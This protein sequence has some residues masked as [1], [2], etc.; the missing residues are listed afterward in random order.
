M[1]GSL[2]DGAERPLPLTQRGRRARGAIID[3]AAT[4]MYQRG[5]SATSLDDVLAAAGSGKS[6]LYHYFADKA[7]LVAAVI[8]R[9]LEIVLAAQPALDHVDSWAGID[10]WAAE[11]L[12]N[13][14]RAGRPVC[15]PTGDDGLRAEERRNI[16]AP[17]RRR[18]PPLGGTAGARTAGDEGSWRAS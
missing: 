10:A 5:V 18:L 4:L 6:Q 8:E 7:D 12:Q 13:A 3:A 1:H 9:Q 2:A 17:S 15:L 16:S 14:C 11:I